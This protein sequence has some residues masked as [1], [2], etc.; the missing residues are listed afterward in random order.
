MTIKVFT[1]IMIALTPIMIEARALDMK[2]IITLKTVKNIALQYP[3]KKGET[4]E[5]TMMAICMVE[6]SGGKMNY[7][8]KQLLKKGIK[9]GS[10]G[11]MQVRLGTAR[12]VA[13]SFKL[14]DVK[15]MSDVELI[16]KMMHE[17]TF[18]VKIATLYIVWL[19]EHSKS[20]FEMVSRYN[21]GKVNH[22]YFNKVQKYMK[23]LKKYKL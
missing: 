21:G 18:N 19:S 20:Y 1:L 12:F 13:K 22:P 23:L 2:Q 14:L 8:D 5:K 6:T 10:Y 15:M 11:I 4:F 16:K 9:K 3:N 7:G 17:S